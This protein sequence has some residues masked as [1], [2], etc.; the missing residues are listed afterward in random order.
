M[1]WQCTPRRDLM[2]RAFPETPVNESTPHTTADVGR[3]QPRWPALQP[4]TRF[5]VWVR[6]AAGREPAGLRYAYADASA[7]LLFGFGPATRGVRELLHAR[8]IGPRMHRFLI[9]QRPDLC[10]VVRFLP[11]VPRSAFR[12]AAAEL[13]DQRVDYGVVSR[14]GDAHLEEIR[15][16]ATDPE[17]VARIVALARRHLHSC[18]PVPS[19]LRLALALVGT[20][21]G[22]LRIGAVADHIGISRQHLSRL[23]AMHLGL[24]LKQ[25]ARIK[26]VQAA[27]A[28][29][30]AARTSPGSE[31]NWAA[32]AREV[33]YY[34]QAHLIRDFK[35]LTGSTPGRSD[36]ALPQG[37]KSAIAS[38]SQRL[39]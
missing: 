38:P 3:A 5:S 14:T 25:F 2:A 15:T 13:R 7:Y 21:G 23:C 18:L 34:D 33:G 32:I 12:A 27:R 11:G 31:V 36:T 6:D 9:D 29:A 8:L 24:T 19:G 17:R 30:A 39:A 20:A 35:A 28:V 16:A 37:S 10:V 22:T 26:R 4:D 1:L